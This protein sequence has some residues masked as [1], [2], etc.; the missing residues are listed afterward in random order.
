[1]TDYDLSSKPGAFKLQPMGQL[2]PPGTSNRA[3]GLF[4]WFLPLAPHGSAATPCREVSYNI[5]RDG[6][7]PSLSTSTLRMIPDFQSGSQTK[8]FACLWSKTCNT[9]LSIFTQ[10]YVFLIMG[11][12][13]AVVNV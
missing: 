2:D 12:G 3:C 1:M 11:L 13:I 10:K 8:M 4:C 9:S 5:Y 7:D 6:S